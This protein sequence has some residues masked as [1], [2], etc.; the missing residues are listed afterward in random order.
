[1]MSN[2][3]VGDT[4]VI[5]RGMVYDYARVLEL[6]ENHNLIYL[7]NLYIDIKLLTGLRRTKWYPK[8]IMN[9]VKKATKKD[10]YRAIRLYNKINI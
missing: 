10:W 8:N 3:K 9:N 6:S 4:F 5:S 2:L 7:D 1:M